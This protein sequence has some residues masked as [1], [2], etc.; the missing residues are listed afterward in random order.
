[1]CIGKKG[2]DYFAHSIFCNRNV[3][4]TM[5]CSENNYLLSLHLQ[6]RFFLYVPVLHFVSPVR[7]LWTV[8]LPSELVSPTFQV[9]LS[10]ELNEL[11]LF[12]LIPKS[13]SAERRVNGI[14]T[15]GF[16]RTCYLLLNCCSTSSKYV[17]PLLFQNVA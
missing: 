9:P 11:S 4:C 8:H 5:L 6:H 3:E 1:M 17:F 7:I 10:L 16:K 15:F 2:K 12:L 13:K 14:S